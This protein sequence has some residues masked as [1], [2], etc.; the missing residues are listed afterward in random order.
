M[1]RQLHDFADH[2]DSRVTPF[3][4]RDR[5]LLLQRRAAWPSAD[6]HLPR[7]A[8]HLIRFPEDGRTAAGRPASV[9]RILERPAGLERHPGRRADSNALTGARS[10]PLALG[11]SLPMIAN[12]LGHTQILVS[13]PPRCGT[14]SQSDF[15]TT[16][17]PM[18][19]FPPAPAVA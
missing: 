13:V 17:A 2:P 11:E 16:H 8:V 14:M 7:V 19:P 1:S 10:A 18:V 5:R 9:Q 6:R 15:I 4:H 3:G 12:L